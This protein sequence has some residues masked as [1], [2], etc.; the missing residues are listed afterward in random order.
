MKCSVGICLTGTTLLF[1]IIFSWL[2]KF[3]TLKF[4]ERF[5]IAGLCIRWVFEWGRPEALTA[6]VSPRTSTQ[7]CTFK[8][9]STYFYGA[10]KKKK[11]IRWQSIQNVWDIQLNSL[12][13]IAKSSQDIF[14]AGRPHCCDENFLTPRL[15]CMLP[16]CWAPSILNI[17]LLLHFFLLHL[18]CPPSLP[19]FFFLLF[20]FLLFLLPSPSTPS[21]CPQ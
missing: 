7:H 16:L 20:A 8:C 1:H 15:F 17:L 19:L 6:G 14:L 13:A 18:C 10:V 4:Q 21:V 9:L 3:T 2:G 5:G 12:A 11:K